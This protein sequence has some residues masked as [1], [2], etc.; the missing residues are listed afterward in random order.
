MYDKTDEVTSHHPQRALDGFV[1]QNIAPPAYE[2]GSTSAKELS[3]LENDCA[4]GEE[5]EL[6]ELRQQLKLLQRVRKPARQAI[7]EDGEDKEDFEEPQFN[8]R[9]KL[10]TFDK[11]SR[12]WKQRGTGEIS[13][14]K[15]KETGKT[16]FFVRRAKNL[17]IVANHDVDP[18]M[19]LTP[20]ARCDRSWVWHAPV[21]VSEAEPGVFGVA[22]R[23]GYAVDANCFKEAFI[24]AQQENGRLFVVRHVADAEENRVGNTNIETNAGEA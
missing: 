21:G 3:G 5:L 13:L 10:F 11:E 19:K 7:P 2:P 23:F 16:R 12:E 17:Q 6:R 14:L 20:G 22:V 15:H 4:V 18:E 24:N 9:G 1:R 8:M